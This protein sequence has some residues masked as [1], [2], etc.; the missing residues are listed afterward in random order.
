MK[1]APVPGAIHLVCTLLARYGSISFE[2]AVTPTLAILDRK[3]KNWHP[4]LAVTLRKL[5]AAER[6]AKGTRVEK[7]SAARDRFYRGDI[8][9]EL[10]R[11]YIEIGALLR[12]RDLAAKE[13]QK[14]GLSPCQ[15]PTPK[16]VFFFDFMVI[17]R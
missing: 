5:V 14:N 9:D 12:K 11:W 1:S 4:R 16:L 10:E 2:R 7:L 15:I 8:A 3:A 17:R 13:S 6:A